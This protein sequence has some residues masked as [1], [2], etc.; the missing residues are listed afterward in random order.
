MQ[1]E[2]DFEKARRNLAK[3]GIAFDLAQKCSMIRFIS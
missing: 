1:F 3:H 2:W